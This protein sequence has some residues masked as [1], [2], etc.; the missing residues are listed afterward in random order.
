MS[1]APGAPSRDDAGR[2]TFS[3]ELGLTHAEFFR[4]LPPAIAQRPCTIE[5]NRVVIEHGDGRVEI[6]LGP[7]QD[8]R[9]A[10][11]RLPYLV[12]RFTFIGL[13]GSEREQFMARFERYF[14]RG[15][16]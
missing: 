4:S 8:R 6:E 11:L 13:S 2:E 9:I 16:G 15:G 3:R 7:R 5:G 1:D 12:A 14:Q 10:S